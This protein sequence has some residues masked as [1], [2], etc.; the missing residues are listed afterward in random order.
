MNAAARHGHAPRLRRR[1]CGEARQ[2]AQAELHHTCRQAPRMVVMRYVSL[3]TVVANMTNARNACASRHS[4]CRM[5][6]NIVDAVRCLPGACIH[7]QQGMRAGE[8]MHGPWMHGSRWWRKHTPQSS[9]GC[10]RANGRY[11]RLPSAARQPAIDAHCGGMRGSPHQRAVKRSP[12]PSRLRQVRRKIS[13]RRLSCRPPGLSWPLTVL[14]A[15]GC[16]SP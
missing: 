5:E 11:G 13:T 16:D 6:A 2:P 3:V 14:G 8:A 7:R 15:T 12:R 9:D 1:E 10:A 4:H